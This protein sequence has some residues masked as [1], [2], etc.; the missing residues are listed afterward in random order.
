ML[1]RSSYTLKFKGTWD[2]EKDEDICVQMIAT[3]NP[4]AEN[5]TSNYND[6]AEIGAIIGLKRIS[7]GGESGWTAYMNEHQDSSAAGDPSAYDG[8]NLVLTGSGAATITVTWDPT[9][10][11]LNRYFSD[12][13][14]RVYSFGTFTDTNENNEVVSTPEVDYDED[15]TTLTIHANSGSDVTNHRTRYN[16]QVYKTGSYELEDWHFFA[17][18]KGNVQDSWYNTADIKVEISEN[19]Q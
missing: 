4:N 12:S 6:L 8:Y 10:I 7:G 15:T 16:I 5:A 14:L 1:F 2:L 3:S 19:V 11:E 18:K 13:L 17:V 9:K